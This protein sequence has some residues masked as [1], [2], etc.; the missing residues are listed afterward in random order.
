MPRWMLVFFGVSILGALGVFAVSRLSPR[1][2]AHLKK[3]EGWSPTPYRDQAGY[4]TIGYGHKIK[5]GEHFTVIDEAM[6]ERLLLADLAQ[7][8]SEVKR[9]VK[10]TLT[11]GQYDALVSLFYN[12]DSE[13]E[14]IV[15]ENSTL[16]RK[17]NAGD[18]AGAADEF[19]KWN[20]ITDP[21]TK[22]K[23]VSTGLSKR[24]AEERE[25]FL[26]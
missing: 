11:E 10:V 9:L 23:I 4:W 1:G 25:I 12:V 5:P 8:E 22:Q 3:K 15:L 7:A 2:I 14:L 18:Y 21:A 17:L 24:R 20:K 26:A 16:L 6:G 19:L 13:P